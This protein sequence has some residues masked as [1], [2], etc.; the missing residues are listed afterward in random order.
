[1]P[2]GGA[3]A[4]KRGKGQGSGGKAND[5]KSLMTKL[6]ASRSSPRGATG[7]AGLSTAAASRTAPATGRVQ[8]SLK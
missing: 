4:K 1:M 8:S 7:G 3:K 6:A 2:K 5:P